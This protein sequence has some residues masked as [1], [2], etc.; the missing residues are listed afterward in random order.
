[1]PAGS[2]PPM[3]RA[4]FTD[5]ELDIASV[6]QEC[7][8]RL[9]LTRIKSPRFKFIAPGLEVPHDKEAFAWHQNFT[10]IPYHEGTIPAVLIFAASGR[11]QRLFFECHYNE[12][13]TLDLGTP[14]FA[15]LYSA[16][17]VRSSFKPEEAGFRL[18]LPFALRPDFRNADGARVSDGQLVRLGSSTEPF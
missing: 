2:L 17:A 1:M 9:V 5:A 13:L 16:P 15:G 18:L 6:P 10:R 12:D 7:F 4:L 3:I 14:I 11:V 8:I